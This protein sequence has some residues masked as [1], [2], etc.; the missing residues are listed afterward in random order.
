MQVIVDKSD[1]YTN[2]LSIIIIDVVAVKNVTMLLKEFVQ[3]LLFLFLLHFLLWS[4][5]G[6]KVLDV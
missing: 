2:K 1:C 3:I 5:G 6:D 4:V